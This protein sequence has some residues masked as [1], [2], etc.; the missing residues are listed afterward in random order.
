MLVYWF[1]AQTATKPP[2]HFLYLCSKI[3][4]CLW[5]AKLNPPSGSS[6]LRSVRATGCS[7]FRSTTA[8]Q[9]AEKRLQVSGSQGAILRGSSRPT[10]LVRTHTQRRPVKDKYIPS[11]SGG[12]C[13]GARV[14]GLFRPRVPGSFHFEPPLNTGQFF[15]LLSASVSHYSLPGDGRRLPSTLQKPFVCPNS[16]R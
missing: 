2:C 3:L 15:G 11:S 13:P 14:Q 5:V 7:L 6:R 10:R 9:V 4:V 12:I 8:T 1:L 16:P